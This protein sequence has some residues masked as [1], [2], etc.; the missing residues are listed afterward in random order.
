MNSVLLET[1]T[2]PVR[3]TD[4]DLRGHVN[5]ALYFV[6]AQ[7]AMSSALLDN[8]VPIYQTEFHPI[9]IE[10]YC[11]YFHPI[12]FPETLKLNVYLLDIHQT[13]TFSVVTEIKSD[14]D[15]NIRYAMVGSRGLWFDF[16]RNIVVKM[17]MYF[18]NKVAQLKSINNNLQDE[19]IKF[20]C[21]IK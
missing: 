6:Y 14:T 15:E 7:E 12:K 19:L 11:K 10:T 8:D 13:R 17:P 20:K 1:T 21:G 2:H 18:V 4:I 3:Y 5:N 9:I 16:I